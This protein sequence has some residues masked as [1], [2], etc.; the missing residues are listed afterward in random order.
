MVWTLFKWLFKEENK[1]LGFLHFSPRHRLVPKDAACQQSVTSQKAEVARWSSDRGK[2]GWLL[3]GRLA[4]SAG[5]EILV[6]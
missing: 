4:T 5:P 1:R 2:A 3:T 6:H